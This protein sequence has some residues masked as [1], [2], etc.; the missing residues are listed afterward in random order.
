VSRRFVCLGDVMIDIVAALPGPLAIGSDTHAPITY[1]AGGSAGNTAAWLARVGASVALIGR[2]GADAMG[3]QARAE[4]ARGGVTDRLVTD[5][6]RPTGTCIVLV[7]SGGERTMIPDPG[8]NAGL[9]GADLD[10]DDF[11]GT[12]HLHVSGYALLGAGRPAAIAALA[13]ARAAGMTLSV[14]AASAAPLADAGASEFLDWIGPDLL[15]FANAAEAQVL[16]GEVDPSRSVRILA[17]AT[18]QAVVKVGAQGAYWCGGAEVVFEP[19]E[20]IEAVDTTGAGDAFA[21]A[22]LGARSAGDS[23][24]AALVAAHALA[25]VACQHI[26]GRP[27]TR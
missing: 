19:A 2:V 3:A 20:S 22:F 27:P 14:D 23:P 5:P 24:A 26:G 9:D 6:D 21:A 7:E 13:R 4:L 17:A 10:A 11:T 25:A 18:G 16:T 15:L 12:G 1:V 8:A